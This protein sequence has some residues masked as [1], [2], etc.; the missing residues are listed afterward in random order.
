MKYLRRADFW[1]RSLF[2]IRAALALISVFAIYT[3]QGNFAKPAV[4]D[5]ILV[6][7]ELLPHLVFGY[8]L[9]AADFLWLRLIQDIDYRES[10]E[11]SKGWA[12]HMMDGITTLD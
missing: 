6:N 3:L 8:K 12:F 4:Q 9:I 7:A 5:K 10:G 1:T 11:V 2:F